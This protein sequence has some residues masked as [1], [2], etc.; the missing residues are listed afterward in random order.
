MTDTETA[1]DPL[2]YRSAIGRNFS[3]SIPVTTRDVFSGRT[4]QLNRVMDVVA[5]GG[6]HAVIY[7]ERGVGKTSLARVINDVFASETMAKNSYHAAY[8]T[9]SSQDTFASIWKGLFGEIQLQESAAGIGFVSQ[10]TITGFPA[11]NL[12]TDDEPTPDA[13]RRLLK[14]LSSHVRLVLFIDEFDRPTDPTVRP[15]VADMIKILADQAIP[16]TLVLIGVGETVDDLITGHESV[17]RSLTQIQMPTMTPAELSEIVERGIGASGMTVD[18]EFVR[19]VTRMSLGLPHYAHLLGS[20]GA[21]AAIEQERTHVELDDFAAAVS[22]ALEDALHSTRQRYHS[23]TT[24]NRETLYEEVLLA[25]ARARRDALGTFGA[26][27]VRDQLREIT[28]RPYEIP[29]FAHH[30]NDFSSSTPPRGGILVKRG[31]VRR[32]RYK[33][34]DPLMPPFVLMMGSNKHM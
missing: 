1:F 20:K 21:L 18:P 9:C 26:V 6:R 22:A 17:H 5:S 27:D 25:C 8:Y 29:A 23:A 15:L 10:P 3:P 24:S 34:A 7:G 12:L 4:E 19:R 32:F 16:V 31:T 33:F 13:V 30:L 28:G 11:S 2:M 14:Q